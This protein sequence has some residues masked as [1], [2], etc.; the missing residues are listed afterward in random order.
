MIT[1]RP[2]RRGGERPDCTI[3]LPFPFHRSTA[4]AGQIHSISWS[5]K[6]LLSRAAKPGQDSVFTKCK[7]KVGALLPKLKILPSNPKSNAASTTN[8][9]Y[10]AGGIPMRKPGDRVLVTCGL[11]RLSYLIFFLFFI[12]F[13]KF[14]FIFQLLHSAMRKPGDRVLVTCGLRRLSY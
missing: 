10:A 4:A 1:D 13:L 7:I 9:C 5:G 3:P 8:I 12:F 14:I 11:Q 2:G 6:G